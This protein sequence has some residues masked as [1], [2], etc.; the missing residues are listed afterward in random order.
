MIR[1]NKMDDSPSDRL[2]KT[3]SEFS[4]SFRYMYFAISR[5]HNARW[6]G[7]FAGEA[8]MKNFHKKNLKKKKCPFEKDNLVELLMVNSLSTKIIQLNTSHQ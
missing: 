1:P 6:R 4:I 3:N 8:L 5:L 2:L 7:P